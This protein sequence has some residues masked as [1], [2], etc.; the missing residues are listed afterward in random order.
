MNYIEIKFSE[1]VAALESYRKDCPKCNAF[2]CNY[3]G[4]HY[5][6][7]TKKALQILLKED[8]PNSKVPGSS[9]IYNQATDDLTLDGMHTIVKSNLERE[10]FIEKMIH[11]LELMPAGEDRIFC[12][13]SFNA[14]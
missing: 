2:M 12:I 14:Y 5:S 13:T 1:V 4:L 6:W 7:A 10:K 3:V 11:R 8:Y 9:S